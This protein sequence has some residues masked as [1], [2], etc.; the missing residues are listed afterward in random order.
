[1]FYKASLFIISIQFAKDVNY[2][3]QLQ[4]DLQRSSEHFHGQNAFL[5]S[6]RKSICQKKTNS[7]NVYLF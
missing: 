7:V 5:V 4:R 1:M 6:E 3:E 2:C